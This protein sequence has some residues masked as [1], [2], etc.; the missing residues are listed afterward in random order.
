MRKFSRDD[1]PKA[2]GPARMS[3]IALDDEYVLVRVKLSTIIRRRVY[4]REYMQRRRAAERQA[5]A[6]GRSIPE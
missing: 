6:T 2:D 5:K 4:Q 1:E 3:S